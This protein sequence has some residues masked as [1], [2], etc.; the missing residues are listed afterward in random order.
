MCN[1]LIHLLNWNSEYTFVYNVYFIV[2]LYIY[3]Y[4]LYNKQILES[5]INIGRNKDNKE[6]NGGRKWRGKKNWGRK[7]EGEDRVGYE[8]TLLYMLII[9]KE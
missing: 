2:S 1:L 9:L 5:K 6:E 4:A 8:H 7:L 3:V